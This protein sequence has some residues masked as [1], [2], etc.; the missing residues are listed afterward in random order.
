MVEVVVVVVVV[1]VVVVEVMV[2]VVVVEVVVVEVVVV[3]EQVARGGASRVPW[4]CVLCPPL[5]TLSND[6]SSSSIA[7]AWSSLAPSSCASEEWCSAARA[8]AS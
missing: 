2:V 6:V 5:L 4:W 1:E 3:G 8:A 7:A